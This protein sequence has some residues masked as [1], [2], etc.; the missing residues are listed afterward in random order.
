MKN[1]YVGQDIVAIRNHSNGMFKE[2]DVFHIKG[3]KQGCC[4]RGKLKIDI[5]HYL[6]DTHTFCTHCK[7]KNNPGIQWY[8]SDSFKPLD[9][10]VNIDELTEVLNE[11]IFEVMTKKGS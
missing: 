9:S 1:F 11:P 6:E 7:R 8:N 5:G 4:E 3:L 2:G 10:L